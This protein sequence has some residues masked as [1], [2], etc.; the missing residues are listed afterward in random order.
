MT[1]RDDSHWVGLHVRR[2]TTAIGHAGYVCSA[3][4]LQQVHAELADLRLR[5]REA[6]ARLAEATAAGGLNSAFFA[7]VSDELRAPMNGVIGHSRLLLASG[8]DPDQRMLVEGIQDSG[9][10]LLDLADDLLDHSRMESG[11][12]EI[13]RMDFDVRVTVDAV[14]SIVS[15]AARRLGLSFS[16]WVHHRVPSRLCGDPARLR[17][18]L[19]G[20]SQQAL[21]AADGGEL[22]LRVELVEEAAHQAVVR[23][24]VNR[25][26]SG[27]DAEA[28][29]RAF[30]AFGDVEGAAIAPAALPG[31]PPAGA[32][33]LGLAISRRIVRLMGGDSGVVVLPALGA[34]LWFRVP[35]GKQAEIEAPLAETT[36]DVG[37]SGL[38]VLVADASAASRQALMARLSQ[39]GCAC[40]E[41][42]GGL[43]AL[44]RLKLSAASGRA[45]A[46]AIM[47]LD[48]P[49]LDARQL[50]GAVRGDAALARTGLVMLTEV[51]RPGDAANAAEWGYDAYFV[52]PMEDAQ[53]QGA[54]R[55]VLERRADP[56]LGGSP[57]ITR[58]TLAEQ[59]RSRVRVLVVEDNPI[60]QLVVLSALR[61]VGYAPE[62]V[63][64][65]AD[66]LAAFEGR[67]F[68]IV[69][70]ELSMA[71]I[72]GVDLARR[73][74]A[75]EVSGR[76][77]PL[78]ALGARER[79]RERCLDAG[80]HDFLAKPIDLDL[81]CAT[82]ERWVQ[83]SEDATAA[84]M[85]DDD[86]ARAEA[87]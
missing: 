62:A 74:R 32:R 11:Q 35:L 80:I 3:Q 31:A 13:G 81:M 42:E 68:D 9:E 70:L 2:I 56:A 21:R 6:E 48:L 28:S 79:D 20:V 64:N 73:M 43:E 8:L 27:Q 39:W 7:S 87:A 67:S 38:R 65:G 66:A 55:A 77:T 57:L 16:S 47:D 75:L 71:G 50:A 54:L 84:D 10:Q 14:A 33:S 78:I 45:H 17:Q 83:Q 46:I 59:K 18:V 49:E 24:W 58:F 52:S 22:A 86:G 29:V 53:L 44:E 69:F 30:S 61:R 60:D 41:A 72:D 5:A 19:L 40:D 1:G 34:R 25:A 76:R 36:P 63:S 85:G 12:L 15:D 51:G 26:C 23:F 4:D 37:L 82:V